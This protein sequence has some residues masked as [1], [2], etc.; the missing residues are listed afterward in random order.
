LSIVRKIIRRRELQ[1]YLEQFI[2]NIKRSY[3]TASD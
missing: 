3:L 1:N 2:A